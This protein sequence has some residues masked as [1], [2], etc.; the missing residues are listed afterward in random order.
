MTQSIRDVMTQNP[1]TVE[2]G[3]TLA[4]AARAMRDADI[5]DVVVMKD[6]EVCGILTDR[7]IVVRAVAEDKNPA[8][9]KVGDV[10]THDLVSV[11]PDDSCDRAKELMRQRAVRRLPVLE[12]GRLT[13]MVSLGDLAIEADGEKILD[14]ISAA[15]PNN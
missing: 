4:D 5:G 1:I 14:D 2:H 3:M 15:R 12:G 11:A 9:C 8:D 7:D 6:G 13:G 10:C